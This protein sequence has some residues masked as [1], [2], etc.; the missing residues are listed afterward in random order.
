MYGW[1]HYLSAQD[2]GQKVK[3]KLKGRK[4]GDQLDDEVGDEDP[5][6]NRDEL[7]YQLEE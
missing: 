4:R 2:V 3:Q 7:D 5:R 1:D 6:D